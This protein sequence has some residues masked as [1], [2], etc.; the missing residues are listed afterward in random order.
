MDS[1][2]S[3]GILDLIDPETPAIFGNSCDVGIVEEEAK[4]CVC[5]WDLR[6]QECQVSPD[7][8]FLK[9]RYCWRVQ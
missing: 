1:K 2:F 3:T 8:Q 9:G 6:I 7:C 5:L 4:S